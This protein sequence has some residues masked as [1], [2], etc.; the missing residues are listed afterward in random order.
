MFA[1]FHVVRR[2]SASFPAVPSGKTDQFSLKR[3]SL[4]TGEPRGW[5]NTSLPKT[6]HKYGWRRSLNWLYP[7]ISACSI[8]K[9]RPIS[10]HSKTV[11]L[12]LYSRKASSLEHLLGRDQTTNLLF[13]LEEVLYDAIC[14]IPEHLL[15]FRNGEPW[16]W[17][18]WNSLHFSGGEEQLIRIR[19][20]HLLQQRWNRP[21]FQVVQK[22]SWFAESE[23]SDHGDYAQCH[24]NNSKFPKA[25]K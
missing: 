3:E 21:K 17:M 11:I 6:L 19:P 22:T 4:S 16:N 25:H 14:G 2:S 13:G 23:Q 1:D 15:Q 20:A 7:Y 8:Q 5:K 18:A 12:P 24:Q 9:I 10:P